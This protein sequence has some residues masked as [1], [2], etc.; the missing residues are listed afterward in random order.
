[1]SI[2]IKKLI[3]IF[4]LLFVS[5]DANAQENVFVQSDGLTIMNEVERRL[6]RMEGDI[7]DLGSSEVTGV[8]PVAN[9]GTGQDLSANNQGDIYYDNGTNEFTRLTPGNSGQFLKTQGTSANPAWASIGIGLIQ[10]EAFSTATS[11][12]ITQ[13]IADGDVYKIIFDGEEDGTSTWEPALR[14]NSDSSGSDY[15]YLI[16]GSTMTG[17]A[18]ITAISRGS[19]AADEI[20]LLNSG[21]DL[22]TSGPFIVE[23]IITG[24]VSASQINF[25]LSGGSNDAGLDIT[26]GQGNY[27][28][29]TPASIQLIRLSGT[30]TISG[31]FYV[32]KFNSN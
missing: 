7:V 17:A 19:V 13:A 24:R 5:L 18:S 15:N 3:L 4:F 9:G 6:L 11:V 10:S 2:A 23:I 1:M 27:A 32:Y 21:N 8:L 26:F 30:G 12:S 22:N 20:P 28:S 25:K 31:R 29:G 16:T 14:I